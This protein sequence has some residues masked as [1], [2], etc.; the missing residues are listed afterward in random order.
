MVAWNILIDSKYATNP[1][2]YTIKE[3][4]DSSIDYNY[5]EELQS[6]KS[7][8]FLYDTFEIVDKK[9]DS[10]KIDDNDRCSQSWLLLL[11]LLLITIF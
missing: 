8:E 10:I 5:S 3:I 2:T 1:P 11:L 4:K 6:I 9:K 7:E